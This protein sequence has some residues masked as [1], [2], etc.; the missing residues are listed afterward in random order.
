MT[1]RLCQ[2]EALACVESRRHTDGETNLSL[3]TGAGKS[4]IIRTTSLMAGAARRLMIFPSL[5][6]LKQ[7]YADHKAEYVGMPLFYLAT[8]GTLTQVHRLSLHMAEI[9][10]VSWIVLTTY[11]SAP[12]I[13][14][15]LTPERVVDIVIHDE[16]HHITG[17]EYKRGFDA[18][19]PYL[20]HVVNLSA[21]LPITKV[22]HYKYP[23]LKGIRDGVVRDFNMELFICTLG[24]RTGSATELL[25]TIV[26]K[27]RR[28]HD[29]VKLLIYT[30]EAN[31]EGADASSVRTFMAA[32]AA[33]LRARGWWME[34]I[35]EETRDREGLL[36]A[37]E[38]HAGEVSILVSCKTLSEGIDLKGANCMLPWDPT[39]SVVD[40]IQ[41]IGRV[42]RLYKTAHGEIA[43]EQSP[44]TVLIPVFLEETAY[45]AC[46]GDRAAID[47]LLA[48]QIA[49]G[50]RGNF[51]PIVNVCTAL[52][53]ELAMEDAELFNQLL[54][55]PYQPRV[56]VNRGLVECVA[57][58][59]KQPVDA[60][61]A[62]VATAVGGDDV[63]VVE[64]IKEGEW[65]E[66]MAGEIAGALATTQ[67]ITLVVRDGEEA[68][69]FGK[70]ERVVTVE[71][72]GA[73]GYKA[74][75]RRAAAADME[76]AKKRIAHRLR[77]DFS[78]GCKVMLNLA[79]IEGADAAGG[80]VLTR[81]T[82]DVQMENWE[83]RR[84]EWAAMYQKLGRCPS[85]SSKDAVIKKIAAWQTQQR[86]LYK[87]KNPRMTV[88]R[89]KLL[90][91]TEGW[92]WEADEWMESLKNWIVQKN[93]SNT[94]S[95]KSFDIGI[96]KAGKWQ[97]HQRTYYK[98]KN[99]TCMTPERIRILEST[100]GWKWEEEDSW[101]AY[102][103]AWVQYNSSKM[104][105]SAV[106]SGFTKKQI[107]TWQ[108]NQRKQYK[109]EKNKTASDTKVYILPERVAILNN[110]EGWKW[111]Q[112]NWDENLQLWIT[113]YNRLHAEPTETSDNPAERFV[114]S[115]RSVQ[116]KAYKKK[117]KHLTQERIAIL[118]ATPGWT[119]SADE[120][121]KTPYIPP[122]AADVIEH[123][124]DDSVPQKTRS[125][126][127]A[128]TKAAPVAAAQP[129]HAR[130]RSQLEEYHKRFKT[131]NAATYASTIAAEPAE[132]AAYHAVADT[133]DARDP[134]ERQPLN[135]IAALLAPY[136]KRSYAAIDLGC[137]MNRLRA[138][139]AVAR[140]NWTSVDVHAADTTVVVA[141]MG[142]L[143]D[144]EET[145]DIA[146]LG[147]SLWARNHA[148]V[149][150]E[151]YRVLKVGGRA[152][153]CESFHRWQDDAGQNT[154]VAALKETGF[155]IVREEGTSASDE[156]AD[157]FQYIVVMK[158]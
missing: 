22:P 123:V 117:E 5:L 43:K 76:A 85:H 3:C 89:I 69:M 35:N 33:T 24:E 149:L 63:E 54:D 15:A 39:A 86:T 10:A 70:G 121:P 40:N 53:S 8:E 13:Y 51:R 156:V 95:D 142:A 28:F 78:D 90:E 36:R 44:S 136:N 29:R 144:E 141:D 94:L 120:P 150:R 38:R 19:A 84:L 50:E 139:P 64:A 93:K 127:P 116:R 9:D 98:E 132:F 104:D 119:W 103:N 153:I 133:Y 41:R 152:V 134:P 83:E 140:M 62:A 138:H 46:G 131:M 112:D 82:T 2:Q 109:L 122:A 12:L 56:A 31:T 60:V 73:D 157:V 11:A 20:K 26:E 34:G 107:M 96:R 143:P 74:V 47:A 18:A 42:L 37:F 124:I 146:V 145:Y 67:G 68:E 7:Y 151:V 108:S 6:L 129:P 61:L 128:A 125:R 16:A 49:E 30:A 155:S 48:A 77:V 115:W 102:R 4:I 65:D 130:Q 126:R 25:I 91:A 55:Y 57:K 147:R 23:L 59:I 105:N 92:Q 101:G 79:T 158:M 66:E 32:H 110:T 27:L 106:I 135:K 100:P 71:K 148:A 81:L 58:Q 88:G 45:E 17:A 52:K 114:A 1:L 75:K 21:T 87:H 137:G 80:M 72:S 111:E 154:L 118:E 97:T 113:I 14:G 99:T